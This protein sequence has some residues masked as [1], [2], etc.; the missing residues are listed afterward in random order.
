LDPQPVRAANDSQN[1][2][3]QALTSSGSPFAGAQCVRHSKSVTGAFRSCFARTAPHPEGRQFKSGPR[4]QI[5]RNKPSSRRAFVFLVLLEWRL[6]D[7]VAM[8]AR[9][10]NFYY[11]F[12]VKNF[13]LFCLV[14]WV[15]L[16]IPV[17]AA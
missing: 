12:P 13:R 9:P 16:N 5:Q 4:N 3:H 10:T 15:S 11:F 6:C 2:L 17:N 14:N 7:C 8:L 1:R